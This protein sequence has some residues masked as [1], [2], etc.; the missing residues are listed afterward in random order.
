MDV[1]PFTGLNEH[2]RS[3]LKTFVQPRHQNTMLPT[4]V[5]RTALFIRNVGRSAINHR[6]HLVA[7]LLRTQALRRRKSKNK[8]SK[9]RVK[10]RRL[11]QKIRH[12][13]L[14]LTRT[15]ARKF[16]RKFKKV[17]ISTIKRKFRRRNNRRLS[18]AVTYSVRSAVRRAGR[19]LRGRNW[20]G[21][22]RR[23]GRSFLRKQAKRKYKADVYRTKTRRSHPHSTKED[24]KSRKLSHFRLHTQKRSRLVSA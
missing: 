18:N 3:A 11:L 13:R 8:H 1:F 24:R 22:I 2:K 21:K 9:R 14:K 16:I 15:D 12:G 23:E 17:K 5:N 20:R 10:T 4:G 19:V 7:H 6:Q